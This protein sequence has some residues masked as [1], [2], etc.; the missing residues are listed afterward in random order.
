MPTWVVATAN[1]GK[2]REIRAILAGRRLCLRGLVELGAVELPEEGD[3]YRANA[4]AKALAAARTCGLPALA[5]DSGLEV[6]AL[7]GAPGPRSARLGGPG[8]DDAGR[9]RRL[10]EALA[11]RPEPWRARFVCAAAWADPSGRLHSALGEC[12]GRILAA[13]R[14][15]GGF[16]Y[17]PVFQADGE[18]LSMAELPPERK[19][20]L[21]HRARA[22]R[23]LLASL[24]G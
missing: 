4:A 23:A 14:G 2:L 1:P 8:L 13:P 24:P 10:L 7:S 6:E 9:V 16:G 20:D 19:N 5:D 21:S 15:A 3:D 17:D 12:R 18:R 11:G 22:F